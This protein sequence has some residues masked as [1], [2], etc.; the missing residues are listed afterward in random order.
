MSPGR[1]RNRRSHPVHHLQIKLCETAGRGL[2]T[3]SESHA[4]WL[5]L[6]IAASLTAAFAS[7][8]L[9]N[10]C[11]GRGRG[12]GENEHRGIIISLRSNCSG[13]RLFNKLDLRTFV[14]SFC[15]PSIP[16]AFYEKK[17]AF[18]WLYVSSWWCYFYFPYPVLIHSYIWEFI[19]LIL[20]HTLKPLVRF[21]LTVCLN[22]T[23]FFFKYFL[24]FM[25]T[26]AL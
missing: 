5:P 15:P 14:P 3:M 25:Y 7:R 24:N 23:Y 19:F 20:S 8:A 1:T 17:N 12:R 9:G 22:G 18:A 2:C 13:F 21:L 11:R 26:L 10:E 4:T 6:G 16:R